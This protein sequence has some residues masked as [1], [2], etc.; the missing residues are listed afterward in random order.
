M[1]TLRGHAFAQNRVHLCMYD[2]LAASSRSEFAGGTVEKMLRQADAT[3]DVNERRLR[4]PVFASVTEIQPPIVAQ[5]VPW[6]AA[7]TH[8]AMVFTY[9]RVAFS[10]LVALLVCVTV[11]SGSAQAN[12][13]AASA[14][15]ATLKKRVTTVPPIAPAP[16]ARNTAAIAAVPVHAAAPAPLAHP[17]A[18]APSNQL[19]AHQNAGPHTCKFNGLSGTCVANANVTCAGTVIPTGCAGGMACCIVQHTPPPGC[20]SAAIARA[21]TWTRVKLQY[22]QVSPCDMLHTLCTMIIGILFP[23]SACTCT[24][25]YD[26]HLRVF[27]WFRQHGTTWI[28]ILI[29]RRC[30]PARSIRIGTAG[31]QIAADWYPTRTRT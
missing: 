19:H 27:C 29:V 24:D 26:G 31:A 30:A 7:S 13:G 20:G 2:T 25:S 11:A 4:A 10:C 23:W 22:C 18:R 15:L 3:C 28:R 5:R 9:R 8:H 21:M 17:V 1:L 12:P 14:K 6:S 16:T